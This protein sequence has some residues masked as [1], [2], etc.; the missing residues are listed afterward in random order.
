MTQ[1]MKK[2]LI[3]FFAAI[4]MLVCVCMGALFVSAENELFPNGGFEGEGGNWTNNGATPVLTTDEAHS[5]E[6]SLKVSEFW[7]RF[8]LRGNESSPN[9]IYTALQNGAE[10]GTFYRISMWTKSPA[11][12]AD[13]AVT[14]G[15]GLQLTG[16]VGDGYVYPRVNMFGG[17]YC[18]AYTSDWMERTSVFGLVREA[19]GT[20]SVFADGLY[21]TS[22]MTNV[23]NADFDLGSNSG[24]SYF[25]DISV[26]EATYTTDVTVTLKDGI[27]NVS[28]KTLI[29]KDASGT[30]LADQPEITENEGVYTIKGL[31]F[32]TL[33]DSYKFA[34]EGVEGIADGVITAKQGSYEMG[35]SAYSAQVTVKDESGNA[36]T[37][38]QVTASVAGEDV[39]VSGGENGVYTIDGLYADVNVTVAK[40]GLLTKTFTLSAEN[41]QIQVVLKSEKPAT[42]IQGNLIVNGNFESTLASGT[43]EP[44]KWNGEAGTVTQTTNNQQDGKY[45]LLVIGTAAYRIDLGSIATDGSEYKFTF[46][47]M[48]E[49]GASLTLSMRSTVSVNSAYAYPDIVLVESKALSD[50]FEMVEATFSISYDEL[51]KVVVFTVNG[52]ETVVENVASFAAIDFVFQCGAGVYLDNVA[53]LNAYD[54]EFVV[55]DG[56]KEL[57]DGLTFDIVGYDG[58]KWDIQPVYSDGKWVIEDACGV[59]QITVSTSSKTFPV[60]VFDAR[61]TSATI[62]TGFALTVTLKD[63]QGNVV[64][65]AQIVAKKG[66]TE[67]FTMTDN[68]D[69]TYSY[70]NAS[71]TFNLYV[72][73]EGYVFPVERNVSSAN[74]QITIVATSAPADE[75]NQG[76]DQTPEKTGCSSVIFGG[77]FLAAAVVLAGSC[78]AVAKK[79]R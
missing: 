67:L 46:A 41:P 75:N 43:Q 68:G 78:A 12:T 22:S 50:E 15:A 27:D 52:E 64:K 30:P 2:A 23:A 37:D 1:S 24:G 51:E 63:A 55:R 60:C 17:M 8:N 26:V 13:A 25:D 7:A 4:V 18:Y 74:T 33:K 70:E 65:G 34:V 73:L 56:G 31:T 28:G 72:T 77:A 10:S 69:G 5:G 39:T 9:A 36:I 42:E 58:K 48:T 3:A 14:L 66:A 6:K 47:A 38:A 76:G 59:V 20:I 61:N 49:S 11:A 71:G 45:G 21:E 19:D 35:L 53:C 44:G 40:Q 54:I 32:N 29:I 79:K 57:S 62:E 16:Q